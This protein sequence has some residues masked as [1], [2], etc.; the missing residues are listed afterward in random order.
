MKSIF[1]IK[2]GFFE[3][4]GYSSRMLGGELMGCPPGG[5][6]GPAPPSDPFAPVDVSLRVSTRGP[7]EDMKLKSYKGTKLGNTVIVHLPPGDDLIDRMK[8]ARFMNGVISPDTL[9]FADLGW[10]LVPFRNSAA[11]RAIEV[12][13]KCVASHTK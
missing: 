11:Y 5:L 10:S 9:F 12:L 3:S 4:R 8:T 7:P 1:F 13:N 2:R 6:G